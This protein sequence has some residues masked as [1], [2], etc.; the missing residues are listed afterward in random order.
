MAGVR[1]HHPTLRNGMYTV[2]TPRPYPVPYLCPICHRTH[3]F[4]ANHIWLDDGG[5]GMVSTGVLAELQTVALAG[6]EIVNE[7]PNPPGLIVGRA[8]PRSNGRVPI[9]GAHILKG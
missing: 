7:V 9:V 8:D 5:N 4:K 6:L 3:F 2:E 1:V